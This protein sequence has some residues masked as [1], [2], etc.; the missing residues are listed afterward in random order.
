MDLEQDERARDRRF[1]STYFDLIE[2]ELIEDEKR[3]LDLVDSYQVIY[4]TLF[5]L[6]EKKQV[7][8]KSS[9]LI[10]QNA[11]ENELHG[12]MVNNQRNIN[13]NINE[14]PQ[15]HNLNQNSF[16]DESLYQSGLNFIAGVIKAEDD[17]KMKRIIFRVSRGRAVATFWDLENHI[18]DNN[19]HNL[20][21]PSKT[22]EK[23]KQTPTIKKKIFTIFFQTGAENIL[24]MKILKICDLFNAS[25]YNIPKPDE[26]VKVLEN[27]ENDITEKRDFLYQAENS[28]KNFIKE[29]CGSEF[30][31]GKYPLYRLYFKKEKIIYLNLNKCILRENFIDGEVWIPKKRLELVIHTLKNIVKNNE[32]KMTA[33]LL[34]V[35]EIQQSGKIPPTYIPVNDF[36]YPF[37]EIVDTYGIPRYQEIN[38]AY[39]NVVTFPFLF[40]VMFGDIGHGFLFLL[41]G[42]YLCLF[43]NS[44]ALEKQSMLKAFLPFRYIL[45]LM[46]LFAFYCGWIYNDFISIPLPLFG[47]CYDN[48]NDTTTKRQPNC[49]YPFGI[50]PK[51]YVATNELTFI[52]SMK[53]KLSVILGVTHMLFGIVLRGFNSIYFKDTIDFVFQV[54]PQIIFMGILF[55]YMNSMIFIKWA[56]NWDADTSKAPSLITQLM[57][58]FIG[59]GS[60]EDKPVWGGTEKYGGKYVQEWFHLGVLVLAIICIPIM[61][62]PKPIIENRRNQRRQEANNKLS[63]EMK[64]VN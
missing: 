62:F 28:I 57:K 45:L 38:P 7:I 13:Y 27:L 6:V 1:G 17:M 60:V 14:M 2:N 30:N 23:N 21:S 33:N 10:R 64:L 3:L 44:L 52:N 53:M 36:L 50:D 40:G 8:S 11:F 49:V 54:I 63:D 47:S 32:A 12:Q 59:F 26:I 51:W 55:G 34:D 46:G 20:M 22:N 39:F 25:R 41:F 42:C 18:L 16:L 5:T 43:N 15:L 56:T 35:N 24:Q 48:L 29:K 4:E 9:L 19:L 37:Q 31:P 58:I 61:L